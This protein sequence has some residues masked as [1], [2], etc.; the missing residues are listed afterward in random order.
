VEEEE[1]VEVEV[2]VEEKVE[3]PPVI[4]KEL[5]LEKPDISFSKISQMGL[6]TFKFT[7]TMVIPANLTSFNNTVLE[8]KVI[9]SPNS[10]EQNLNFSWELI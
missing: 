5:D 2:E 10:E 8:L 7:K 9:P 4:I 1:E 3:L 6:A